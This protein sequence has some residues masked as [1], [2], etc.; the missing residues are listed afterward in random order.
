[1]K[2]L[3]LFVVLVLG[4]QAMQAQ[5]NNFV[6]YRSNV[7][8]LGL[9]SDSSFYIPTRDT[10]FIPFNLGFITRRPQDS[11]VYVAIKI[12]SGG[13][14]WDKFAN[15]IGATIGTSVDTTIFHSTNYHNTLY[16]RLAGSYSNPSWI[17]ALAFAKITGLQ[18]TIQMLRDS[19]NTRLR[20][21]QSM[22]VDT[23]GATNN[24]VAI[25]KRTAGQ[26][27]TIGFS[28]ISG[29][30][31]AYSVL[32]WRTGDENAPGVG[33]TLIVN[34]AF[35]GKYGEMYRGSNYGYFLESVVNDTGFTRVN[36]TTFKVK[37]AFAA[38][39]WYYIRLT[40]SSALTQV[41]L[42][43]PPSHGATTIAYVGG[44]DGGNNG[45]ATTSRTFSFTVSSGSDRILLVGFVGDLVSG[46]DD[47]SSVTYNGV[48]MTLANKTDNT[49]RYQYLYYMLNPPTGAHNVVITYPSN[50]WILAGASEY[51]GVQ[52]ID[53]QTTNKYSGGTA[54]TL[55]TSL[56]TTVNNCWT[57]LFMGSGSS[58]SSAGAGATK[59]VY[60]AANYWSWYDSGSAI[61]PAGSHSM[62]TTT[63]T[64]SLI[65]HCMIALKPY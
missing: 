29:G 17:T 41:T 53:V 2:K 30:S 55:T 12:T 43:A 27:D 40:D 6:P 59:R 24:Q 26:P 51:T 4:L 14:H 58:T 56:T 45:G 64:G 1:M 11:I 50:R 23:T 44:T 16:P 57:V 15:W 48:A 31:G 19:L 65:G 25:I 34:S 61:T 18:D 39:E 32:K 22:Y 54:S 63:A 9:G 33:D 37:P 3:I 35:R 21:N 47:V 38:N 52:G 20:I 49:S 42:Q 10:T 46:A 13:K 36:D 60:D 8:Y 62:T 7:R 28:T 5:V